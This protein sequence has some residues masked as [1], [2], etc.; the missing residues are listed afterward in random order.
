MKKHTSLLCALF[1]MIIVLLMNGCSPSAVAEPSPLPTAT[2]APTPELTPEDTGIVFPFGLECDRYDTDIDISAVRH[3]QVKETAEL[4]KTMPNLKHVFL[5]DDRTPEVTETAPGT[6]IAPKDADALTWADRAAVIEACGE[7]DAEYLFTLFGLNFSTLDTLMDLNHIEMD[8]QGA[9]VEAVLPCMKKCTYLDMDFCGVDDEHMAAIRDAYPDMEVVWRIW[10]GTDCSVRTD[11][12]RILS[13][14]LNHALTDDNTKSLKYCTKVKYLDIG[15]QH[16]TDISFLSYMPDLEVCI[17][18]INP[19]ADLTP[20]SACTNMEYLEIADCRCKDLTPLGALTK[21]HHL[22]VGGLQGD[23]TGWEALCSLTELERLWIGA[24]TYISAEDETM[25]R[26]ALPNTRIDTTD[27]GGVA[28]IW[29]NVPNGWKEERYI[30][31]C[32]Q[33]EYDNYARVCSSYFN[34]PK[35]YSQR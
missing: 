11:V 4:L 14:N 30:L 35:Y 15:H 19:I 28:G 1:I 27:R 26:R 3:S 23:V 25:L 13:S 22:H 5:G 9:A 33:F 10:F 20:I 21:L 34:D 29:R 17:I 7:A 16:V 8:D 32:E 24:F 31:L 18:A 12:E 2:P 6:D